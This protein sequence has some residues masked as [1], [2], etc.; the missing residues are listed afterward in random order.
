MDVEGTL[1]DIAR[2]IANVRVSLARV[3][4]QL[5]MLAEDL[6][7]L[8]EFRIRVDVLESTTDR[9]KAWSAGVVAAI[10]TLCSVLAWLAANV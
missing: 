1:I 6:D 7:D 8:E 10:V 9:A 3:E 2:E 5:S 4:E